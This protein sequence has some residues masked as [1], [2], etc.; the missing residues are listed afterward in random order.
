MGREPLRALFDEYPDV[1]SRRR[2]V[3]ELLWQP[4]RSFGAGSGG[5]AFTVGH[6]VTRRVDGT[7]T[8]AH[9]KFLTIWRENPDGTWSY[10]FDLGSPRP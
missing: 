2:G 9:G 1:P 4:M 5:L 10:I 3:Y 8:E 6:S 7:G